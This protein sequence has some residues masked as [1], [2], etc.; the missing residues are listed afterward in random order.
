MSRF[1]ESLKKVLK[2]IIT[3]IE[4]AFNIIDEIE[5]EQ[6]KEKNK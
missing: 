5:R 4:I 3:D 1:T 2:R 6:R